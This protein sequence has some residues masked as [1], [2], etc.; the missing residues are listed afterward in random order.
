MKRFG[1]FLCLFVLT[2]ALLTGCGCTGPAVEEKNPPTVLPTNE[3]VAPTTRETTRPTTA[4]TTAPTENTMSPTGE[5]FD[6]GNGGL[7]GTTMPTETAVP[8]GRHATGRTGAMG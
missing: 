6:R 1:L 7:E 8:E 5:T 3:E 2:A 4:P